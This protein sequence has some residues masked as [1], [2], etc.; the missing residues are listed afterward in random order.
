MTQAEAVKNEA[1]KNG[2]KA[3]AG[4]GASHNVPEG[5]I[6]VGQDRNQYKPETCGDMPVIGFLLG[7]IDLPNA[8]DV[9]VWS[10][11]VVRLTQPVKTVNREDQIVTAKVGDEIIVPATA[12]LKQAF[13]NVANRQDLAFQVFIQPT[14]KQKLDGGKTMW[15]YKTAVHKDAKP[16]TGELRLIGGTMS[17]PVGMGEGI[18]NTDIPF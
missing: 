12:K 3:P 8:G 10:A 18:P 16:R 1:T 13:A 14:H 6:E 15:V 7:M 5:F 17:R 9:G 4:A 2:N 11:L